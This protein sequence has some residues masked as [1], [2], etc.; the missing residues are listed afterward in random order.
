MPFEI[1][2]WLNISENYGDTILLGNGASI[3]VDQRFSYS[4][5]LEYANDNGMLPNDVQQLFNFFGTD[6]FELVLRLVWQASNV[7]LALQIADA[8]TYTAYVRVRDSLIQAVRHIHPE[9]DET[10][11]Q[12]PN[13]YDFLKRFKTVISLN[14]DLI[15]YW[16][17]TYGF[18]IN[19]L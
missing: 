13:I 15:V 1:Q 17:M 5:L 2:P 7:N 12:L 14:Y 11:Q 18:D 9:Y 19:E 4:S 10:S 8:K 3:A 6:D 16:A